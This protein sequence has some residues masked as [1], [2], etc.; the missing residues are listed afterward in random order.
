MFSWP[1]RNEDLEWSW[2]ILFY[3]IWDYNLII[4]FLHSLSSLQIFPRTTPYSPSNYWPLIFLFFN[5]FYFLHIRV[6][7]HIYIPNSNLFS[8]HNVYLYLCFSG[9]IIWRW[10]TS[11]FALSKGRTPLLF[12]NLPSSL[13]SVCSTDGLFSIQ[14]GMFIVS[15][16]F[17]S[18]LG[19]NA[20]ETLWV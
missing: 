4:I 1:A 17:S 8:L 9:L 11:W 2:D 12:Q 3:F 13:G 7:I 18:H 14:S 19:V 10:T 15:S 20:D 5:H 16:F 6:C